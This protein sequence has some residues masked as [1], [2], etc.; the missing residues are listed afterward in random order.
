[1]SREL[2][3]LRSSEQKIVLDM[4]AV[5]HPD[6][7]GDA[8]AFEKYTAFYGLT[9]KDLGLYAMVDNR[10]VGA[11]WCRKFEDEDYATLSLGVLDE[12]VFEEIAPYMMEQFLLEAA[13]QY[14]GLR[15]EIN[16]S[17]SLQSFYESFGF[18]KQEKNV[19]HLKLEK[20]EIVRPSDGCDLRK[21]MD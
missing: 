20:K 18:T 7:K 4:F 16:A 10:V 1:M 9:R 14:E 19:W 5:A 8:Y 12:F 6:K 13:S 2:Y 21:W 17:E 11:L 15:V 3:F